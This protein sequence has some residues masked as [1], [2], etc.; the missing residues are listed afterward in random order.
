MTGFARYGVTPETLVLTDK[1]HERISTL[2][3]QEVKVW[4]G[5]EFEDTSVFKVGTDKK[6]LR[7]TTTTGV[8]LECSEDHVFYHQPGYMPDK[9][10]ALEASELE[11][12][13]RLLKSPSH[14]LITYGDKEFPHAYSHGYFTGS[15]K[16]QR[17]H[18]V[19]SRAA[20][21][22]ARH[23]ALEHLELDKEKTDKVNL[24]FV[25]G[26][27]GPFELPVEAGYS[28]ETRLEWLA[29]LT[30]AG[31]VKRKIKPKPIW[32]LYT[33]NWDFLVQLKLLFQ[34]LGGDVRIT[35]NDDLCRAPYSIRISHTVMTKLKQLNMKT[36][37]TDIPDLPAN[38]RRGIETPK[39][40]AVE[41]AYRTSD[42]YNFVGTANGAAVFNGLYTA[43][44]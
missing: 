21:F 44:N 19:A 7:V 15:E 5:S 43:S 4:T 32:H 12:G 17:R 16:Y 40:I 36:V 30:D 34:T 9:L 35:K 11:S 28:L 41:D 20:I 29:G 18:G 27:P 13:M 22:S 1:G 42:V 31:I 3:G 2:E 24:H 39:I 25:E 23:P 8:E 6:I 10:V 37:V 33:Y 14:P 26:L 38:V